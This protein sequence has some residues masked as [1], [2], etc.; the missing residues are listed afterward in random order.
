M[1]SSDMPEII[2]MSTRIITMQNGRITSEMD[3]KDITQEELI[4]KATGGMDHA[5]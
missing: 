2:N 3:N 4:I 5:I 1:V